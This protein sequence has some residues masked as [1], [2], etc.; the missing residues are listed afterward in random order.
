MFRL[1]DPPAI[2]E[3]GHFSI[4]PH[5]R[6]LLAEGRPI[7]LG[8]RAFDL[9]LALT[10]APGAV[11]DKDELL[12]RIWP[13]RI[14]EENRLQSEISALRK[15]FGADRDL[16][17]TIAG[18]GYQ[19][20][21]EIRVRSEGEPEKSAT[22][23]AAAEPP[24]AAESDRASLPLPDK[25][26]I[27]VLP[28]S[29]MSG[30]PEREYFADGMVEE[31]I[32]ALSRIRWLFVTA[33]NSSF[34]Y[35]GQNVD[36]KRVGQELGVRY[37][38][39]GSVRRSRNRVRIAAQL[40]DV[41]TGAHLWAD[42]FDGLLE[43]VF[44]LQ[45]KVASSVA[46]VIEPALQAAETARSTGRPTADLT[47]YDLYLRA[48]AMVW[49]ARQIP[50]A[51]DLLEHAIARDPH[52]GPALAWS[53]MC[54]YRLCV[55]GS[56]TDPDG[57]SRKGFDFAQ[58]ALEVAGDDPEVIVNAALALSYFGED[59]N[60]MIA[61]VDRA[62]A[63]NPNF[64]RGWHVGGILRLFAAQPEL[65]IEFAETALRLSPRARVGTSLS[66]IGQALFLAR[67]FDES[68]PK[69]LLAI[70][71]DPSFPAPYRYL[72][73]CYAHMGR[74]A[75]ARAI[76]ARL[77]RITSG[78]G[79]GDSWFRDA[80]H[81]DL[82]LSGL[83]LAT[84]EGSGAIAAPAMVDPLPMQHR[85]AERRQIT[86]LSCEL[87]GASPRTKGVALEDLHEAVGDFHR[88]VSE[89]ADR[90]KGFVYRELGND[91]LVLFG[92][93]EAH[94]HDAER[95]IHAGLE[96]CAAVRT[97]R[98]D[99][100]VPMRCRVGIATGMV[101][102]GDLVGAGEVRDHGI[103]GDAPD[104]AVRL[105]ISAQPDTVT[106]EPT[107]WRLIGNL[108]DCCD[109]GALDTNGDTEP[110]R[111]LQVLGESVVASRFEALR[112]SQLTRLVGRDEEIDLLL[113]RWARAKAGDGQIMMV[114]GEAGLGKSRITAAFEERLHAEP[115]L[116]LRYFCSP[117]HQ[118]SA[119]FPI[120]DQLGRAAGF[121][122]DDPPASKLEK[123]E[124]LLARAAPPDED[125]ALL[126]DLMSLPAAERHPL[127]NLSPQRKKER[128]LEALIRQL[129]GLAHEQP[130]VTVWEDAHWLDPTSLELLD[131]TVERVRSL[132]A[133]LIVT[134][135]PEFQ[136]PWAGQPQVNMLALNR[137]DR[138]DCTALIAQIAGSKTLPDEVVSQIAERTDGVPL[139]VEELTKS[140]LER[141]LLREEND[142]HVLD[143]PLQPLA[144]PATL[145][146]SLLARLDRLASARRVAQI[147][148][149]IG[150]Q[151]SYALLRAV[152]R[153][154]EDELQAALGQLVA[155]ELVSQRGLPPEAVYSFKHAL[156]QDAAHGSLLR[157]VR[158][159]LHAQI[160]N[161]L[162]T[163]SPEII[164]SQPELLAQHYAEAGLVKKAVAFW[165]KAGYRSVARSAMAEAAAQFQKGLDQL[166][167][168]PDIPER[169]QKELEFFSAL[170]A[171]L[172]VV[173]GSAAPETGQAYAR[174][175]ELWEQ[176]GSP[177]EFVQVPC[178]QSRYHAHRGELDLALRLDQDLLCLSRRR[179][180]SAGLVMGDY[181][182]GRNLM[183]IG[184]FASSRSHLENV[185]ALYDPNSHRSLVRQTGIHPQLAAQA[186]LG[187]VLLCL[188]FPD[189]ALAQSNKAIAE[190]RRLP[191]PP[192]LAMS[193][194]MDAL[195]LSIIG[196]DTALEQR[197]DDLVATATDQGFPFYR[198]TAAIF[199]G[200]VKAKNADVTEGLSLLRAG[201]SAY[202]ATG[203]TVW[204]PL[205]FTLLAR[206]CEI[207][208]Q[209]EE[210]STRLD[211]A[212]QLVE[213]TGERWFAAE[214]DRQRGRLLLGQG[215]PKVAEEL[216]R[217]A[218]SIAEEQEAKLWELRAAASLARLWRDQGR[219]GAARD[220]LGPVYGWFTEG[221]AIPDLKAAKMLL[222][223][224]DA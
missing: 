122:R 182:S 111:R 161:A 42:H 91:A 70:Q 36:V 160:A 28:F 125:V 93:P 152:S 221:F 123:L 47:A 176:L 155:S 65:A 210:G 81:R 202:G 20:T 211:Q 206:A 168:L 124:A 163:H 134:F 12:R 173:K 54:C 174:A 109:L 35:K 121:V 148:A 219:C 172:N 107:T 63:L 22:V 30:D 67:R 220:L 212:V 144:I 208:G 106:I 95:A 143:R 72:A 170:G 26:S 16:I 103:V 188:G 166:A 142:R 101:I 113:R 48:H 149:A 3:F 55:D 199:R 34:A 50:E 165:G 135:R 89:T 130:V 83:R 75:E 77:Q 57:D 117:Y 92:Y 200:W 96:L 66:L 79:R 215:H 145:Q 193:L 154:P 64:A 133:L 126:A 86:A 53:A 97:L 140:V 151:F 68:V 100:D 1:S 110:I 23:T 119:L 201:S 19:F 21:G 56:G 10:E 187:V 213:T 132:P 59:I 167:A 189:Q 204:M 24:R 156:V 27:A 99:A 11:V 69:L 32:T 84:G 94:E 52:Y 141:G 115:H 29:N 162:E 131:V 40:I 129:E 137:L 41:G 25:P 217:K 2:I 139:F 147:G 38:L 76:V 192:S 214:L 33:R 191:H 73:A 90:H 51:L 108:F 158:Q 7:R 78:L 197:A 177:M 150:R 9:L 223:E 15:A 45:D 6:Q 183:W 184:S 171:V 60:A 205:Y 82:Y 175:R 196:D 74:L 116:R 120:I 5:R 127:P 207:A 164:E 44:D 186:A 4:L 198:A 98:H 85:E 159:Q 181:S 169:R 88:C 185:L 39:E 179:N 17:Q 58:R 190:A 61:L 203:A 114:S 118:D 13:G 136:P 157:N 209:I 80:E 8:G 224:L 112:G 18:R 104:L 153:V 105:Q 178:G 14:V 180:D 146:A 216:Y 138:R 195:L 128:T 218:L 87:V 43:D 49:S 46:G 194:G 102:V 37:V 62:L 31:I 222:D 71:E